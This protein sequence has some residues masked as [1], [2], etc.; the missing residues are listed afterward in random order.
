MTLDYQPQS[1]PFVLH[2]MPAHAPATTHKARL[3]FLDFLRCMAAMSVLIQHACEKMFPSFVYFTTHYFQFGVFGVS[4]FFLCS[5][6]VIPVSLEKTHSLRKFWI[7]RVFR[8][9]PLYLVSMGAT[10]VLIMADGR[11]LPS[12]TDLLAN[13]TMLQKFLDRPSIL[14]LYWTLSLEMA[15]YIMVSLI[16][17]AGWLKKTVALA[18]A[19]LVISLL[20]GVVGTQV[21]HLFS[22]GWGTAF[23]FS[24]M[25][26]GFLYYR[27]LQGKVGA[28]T[29][30]AVVL[31]AMGT[32]CLITYFNLYGKDKPEAMGTLSFL[33]VTTAIAGAYLLFSLSFAAR[34]IQYPGFMLTLGVISYSLY[35]VQAT[36][37]SIIPAF[38]QPWLTVIVWLAAIILVSFLTY[39]LVEKPFMSI[40]KR[41]QGPAHP[42]PH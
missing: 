19:S 10:L 40:G 36:V 26:I 5:G 1:I 14:H 37:F 11:P 29:F 24:T 22:N 39:R 28:A 17:L 3:E 12:F 27:R 23:Y 15:F 35:L 7:N 13:L 30:T 34:R 38:R 18:V 41:L 20:I 32:L 8:L 2:T 21:F 33:P 31:A 6:F 42:K 9:Y 25:F 16:F 4:L